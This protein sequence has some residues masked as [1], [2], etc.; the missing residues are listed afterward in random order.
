MNDLFFLLAGAVALVWLSVH[1][2]LG[3]KQ[4][5]SPIL[6]AP[7]L[8]PIVRDTQYLCWHFTSVAIAAMAVL[9]LC[10]VIVAER[11]YAA[12]AFGLATGFFIVG[13]GLVVQL[14]GRHSDLP[15]GWLFLPVAMLGALGLWL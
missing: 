5:A 6:K 15:Q 10:A 13:V 3:G 7:D 9:N 4:I 1:L 8:D 14:R 12:A 2:F 11:A